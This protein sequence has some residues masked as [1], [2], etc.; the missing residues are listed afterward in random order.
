MCEGARISVRYRR[1]TNSDT[2]CAIRSPRW[3][4]NRPEDIAAF[5]EEIRGRV[6]VIAQAFVLFALMLALLRCWYRCL[7]PP[8]ARVFL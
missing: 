4:G 1:G 3:S 5:A 6:C 8:P 7:D 2:S